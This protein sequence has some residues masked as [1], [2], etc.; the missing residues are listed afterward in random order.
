MKLDELSSALGSR[1][2]SYSRKVLEAYIEREET[3]DPLLDLDILKEKTGIFCTLRKNNRLR[4]CI[5]F[6]YPTHQLGEALV[7]STIQAAVQDPR[8]KKVK[9]V[10]L[11]DINIELT[12]LTPPELITVSSSDDILKKI[13]LG[14][15]GLIIDSGNNKGLLLPQVPIEQNW[16]IHEYLEGICLK[17]FLPRDSWKD[18]EKVK[19]YNFQGRI[20]E[21]GK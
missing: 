14:V 20:F 3:L 19:L 15:D 7:K 9:I 17:A 12:V 8:F 6:P 16:T 10:E 18:T 21:E 5:G 11:A 2:T 4:G 13:N 1:L